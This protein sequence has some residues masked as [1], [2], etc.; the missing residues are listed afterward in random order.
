VTL[1][2]TMAGENVRMAVWIVAKINHM[3]GRMRLLLP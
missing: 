2:R 1:M 3:D